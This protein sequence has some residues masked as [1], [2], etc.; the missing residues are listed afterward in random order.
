MPQLA[1]ELPPDEVASDRGC[2]GRAGG[3]RRAMRSDASHAPSS[4]CTT[5]PTLPAEAEA[6]FDRQFKRARGPDEI[7]DSRDPLDAIDGER[8]YLPRVL[9]ELGLASSGSEARRLIGQHGVKI[10]GETVSVEEVGLADLK[11]AVVQVG[12]RRFVR[13][14]G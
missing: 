9:A 10:N 6:A 13:L 14:V 1:T 5:V 3:L 7:P 12:K 2:S 8:V 11:E 4:S